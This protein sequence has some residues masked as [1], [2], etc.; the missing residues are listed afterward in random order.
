MLDGFG[1]IFG[2][3]K[4]SPEVITPAIFAVIVALLFN[5][6]LL[7]AK[8]SNVQI[9]WLPFAFDVFKWTLIFTLSGWTT[10]LIKYESN[11]SEKIFSKIFLDL[12]V[13]STFISFFTI[14]GLNLYIIPGMAIMFFVLYTPAYMVLNEKVRALN[15]LKGNLNFILEDAHVIHTLVALLIFMVLILIPYVGEYFAIFFYVLWIPNIYIFE[16]EK[17]EEEINI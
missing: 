15:V 10:L 8:A 9:Q 6:I 16:K 4:R 1:N 11:K 3:V 7:L 2:M 17:H 5:I 12:F 14:V 13:F